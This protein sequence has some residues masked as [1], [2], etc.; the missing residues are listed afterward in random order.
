MVSPVF[1]SKIKGVTVAMIEDKFKTSALMLGGKGH[2]EPDKINFTN[3]NLAHELFYN[4][5]MSIRDGQGGKIFIHADV[6]FDGVASAFIAQ[7]VCDYVVGKDSVITGIN[8]DRVHGITQK[9]VDTVKY[10]NSNSK[11]IRLAIIVDSSTNDVALIRQMNCDVIVLDHHELEIPVEET[12][13][14]T[15]GGTYAIVNKEI[16]HIPDMSGAQVVYEWFRYIGFEA[17]LKENK[18]YS[19]AGVSLFSDVIDGDNERNQWYIHNIIDRSDYDYSLHTMFHTLNRYAKGSKTDIS[20]RLVPTINAAIRTGHSDY[21]LGIVMSSPHDIDKL[22]PY[23]AEQQAATESAISAEQLTANVREYSDYIAYD[24]SGDPKLIGYEGLIATKLIDVYGKTAIVYYRTE[25]GVKG[26]FR[27]TGR[28]CTC[29]LRTQL[30]EIDGF[31]AMGHSDAFGFEVTDSEGDS[32]NALSTLLSTMV[33]IADRA[34]AV[35]KNTG[36]YDAGDG[37]EFREDADFI[38]INVRSREAMRRLIMTGEIAK[39]AMINAHM[40]GRRKALLRVPNTDETV[41]IAEV[42]A[43]DAKG[44]RMCTKFDILG[45]SVISFN[46]YKGNYGYVWLYPEADKGLTVYLD[47]IRP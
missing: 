18:L 19:W 4:A 46:E 6:D 33:T 13:G 8:S 20:F 23:K 15:V 29:D 24:T 12:V 38:Y 32:E 3:S 28:Y 14:N 7:R 17:F 16:D 34:G 22:L 26:S 2:K 21:M 42:T 47:S 37:T 5:A 30:N 10:V 43:V 36:M 9:L 41:K 27:L 1:D 40:S 39:M 44:K 11:Q 35:A 25:H 45:L 31:Y